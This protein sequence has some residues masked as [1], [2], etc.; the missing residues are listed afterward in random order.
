MKSVHRKWLEWGQLGLIALACAGLSILQYL[1]TGEF[2]QAERIRQR[3]GLNEQVRRLAGAFN[4]GLRESCLALLPSAE[5]LR[6]KGFAEAHLARYREWAASRQSPDLF[7]RITVAVPE[8]NR[9][10]LYALNPKGGMNDI[11]WPAEWQPLRDTMMKR[12]RGQGPPP[13]VSHSSTLIELPVF[14]ASS[15]ARLS[16]AEM[17]WMIL[18]LSLEYTRRELLPR[19]AAEYLNPQGEPVFDMEVKWTGPQ[20]GLV[21]TTR[22][23]GASRRERADASAGLFPTEVG[24]GTVVRRGPASETAIPMRWELAVSHRAG[25]LD[26]AV[27]RAR[28]RNLVISLL[29]IAILGVAAWSLVRYT[30]RLRRLSELQ[31]QFVAGVSHDLRTPLTAI[32]G[33]AF[34]MAEGVVREPAPVQR[35]ARLILR[36]AEA[37]AALVENVLAFSASMHSG[38]QAS[39]QPVPVKELLDRTAAAALPEIEQAGCRLEVTV[40][41]GLPPILGDAAALERAFRNLI[42]NAVNHAAQGRWIGVSAAA[43]AEGVEVRVCDRGPGIPSE[44]RR[45]IFEPFYRGEKTRAGRIRGTG[46]GLT[47]VQE[48]VERHGGAVT[49]RSAPGEGAQFTVRLPAAPEG[50]Q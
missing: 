27:A 25:S 28:N 33:A 37:L 2:S 8:Q 3:A 31:L 48:T 30:A 50:S 4:D 10:R 26:A 12:L 22:N 45:R 47:V 43:C 6:V 18:E 38:A 13:F 29:L 32:R 1:W 39:L 15:G 44:E 17:E 11:E 41:P 49:V 7:L 24:R 42:S 35:Y 9:L 40:A 36:N 34:N 46:L 14:G 19:L 5:E 21:F 16:G 20:G 23:A